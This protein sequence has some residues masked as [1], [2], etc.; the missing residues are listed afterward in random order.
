[1]KILVVSQ[2]PLYASTTNRMQ[3]LAEGLVRRGH[4]VTLLIIGNRH[5]PGKKGGVLPS[6]VNGLFIRYTPSLPDAFVVMP[7]YLQGI[8]ALFFMVLVKL[9]ITFYHALRSEVVYTSKPLPYGAIV[10][11]V[12]SFLAGKPMVLDMDD[13]EGVGGFA[14]IKQGNRALTKAVITYFEEKIPNLSKAVVVV[15]QLL[16]DRVKLGGVLKEAI[17]VVPNGA[18]IERFSPKIDGTAIRKKY[19]LS[20][21]VLIYVGT[22][23]KGGA[24]W[25]MLIDSFAVAART[26]PDIKLLVVGFGSELEIAQ[27]HAASLGI[28]TQAIFAGKVENADVPE[29][30]AAADLCLLPY[31]DD[32][33]DTYINIGRSSLKLYEYM[34]MGKPVVATSVG[35][36]REALKEGAGVLIKTNDPEDFGTAVAEFIRLPDEARR[37]VGECARTRAE[38][39][40]NYYSL[41]GILEKALFFALRK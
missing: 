10:S 8:L 11:T 40:Y 19:S 14:T 17:F 36:V 28:G 39:L 1:M 4:R 35:E 16:A 20:G 31:Q 15:S 29:Y 32:F 34:A 22:F 25:K 2:Y 5:L 9:P 37:R 23:K 7:G 3:G 12:A 21:M 26:Q 6:E 30:L 41:S 33:P 38:T 24:N 13:W 27:N 18:D